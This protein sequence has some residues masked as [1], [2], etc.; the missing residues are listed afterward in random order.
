MKTPLAEPVGVSD[1]TAGTT[2]D[3]NVLTTTEPK[4]LSLNLTGRHTRRILGGSRAVDTRPYMVSFKITFV[5][6]LLPF[7]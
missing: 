1:T 6:R 5:T 2:V 3:N 7:N 4:Q